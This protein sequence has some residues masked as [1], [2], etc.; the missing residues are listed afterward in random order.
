MSLETRRFCFENP[1]YLSGI[2]NG[3]AE[4]IIRE[5]CINC[6]RHQE[7]PSDQFIQE[8]CS[9]FEIKQRLLLWASSKVDDSLRLMGLEASVFNDDTD[10]LD[11]IVDI[12]GRYVELE[13]QWL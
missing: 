3:T 11:A 4:V 12:D 8:T 5:W 1:L 6:S 9:Q 13:L 2:G 7:F 10:L